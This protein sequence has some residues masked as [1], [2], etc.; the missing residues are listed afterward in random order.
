MWVFWVLF[1]LLW[2]TSYIV[3][4]RKT[5]LERVIAQRERNFDPDAPISWYDP[6]LTERERNLDA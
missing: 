5:K 4:N 1:G 2:L 3:A 6:T